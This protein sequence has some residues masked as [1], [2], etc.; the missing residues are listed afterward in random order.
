WSRRQPNYANVT[1]PAG[2]AVTATPKIR[3][4]FVHPTWGRRGLARHL[5]E[6]AETDMRMAGYTATE[7]TATIAGVPLYETL[8][9]K[10][11]RHLAV[12]LPGGIPLPLV[13]MVKTLTAASR[14]GFTPPAAVLD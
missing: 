8:G 11:A 12:T 4:V 5:V 13:H 1:G 3:S 6:L 7:L 14:K 9:F 2:Q 10:V